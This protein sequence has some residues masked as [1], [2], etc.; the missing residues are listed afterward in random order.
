VLDKRYV[1]MRIC[2]SAAGFCVE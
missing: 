1:K 2:C